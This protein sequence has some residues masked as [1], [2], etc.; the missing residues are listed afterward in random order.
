MTALAS[1]GVPAQADPL[2]N[3]QVQYA[4][5]ADASASAQH[6]QDFADAVQRS[7]SVQ[8]L[9]A[10]PASSDSG[11]MSSITHR[12]D[13]IALGLRADPSAQSDAARQHVLFP[14]DPASAPLSEAVH[15]KPQQ[16]LTDALDRA[17]DSYR[18]SVVFSVQAEVAS[19][20]S[21]SSTKT[22]NELMKGS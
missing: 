8:Q 14:G 20:G 6:Q 13:N 16:S 22:F 1:I 11:M 18:N 21:T 10:Q 5:E 17:L 19:T 4:A 3:Q 12:L 2:L 7:N 9:D 15:P